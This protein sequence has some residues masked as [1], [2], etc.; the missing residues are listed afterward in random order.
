M[1]KEG[2]LFFPSHNIIFIKVLLDYI[3]ILIKVLS[4]YIFI[5]LLSEW[6]ENSIC[7]LLPLFS[8]ALRAY[9]MFG[10]RSVIR[11][12]VENVWL[13]RRKI[14]FFSQNYSV[15]PRNLPYPPF[16][17]SCYSARSW[18]WDFICC[19]WGNR[20][21]IC[22]NRIS[23]C[24]NRISI[25]GNRISFCANRIKRCGNNVK[26]YKINVKL[27]RRNVMFFWR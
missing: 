15:I 16:N 22:D 13:W 24:D 27:W 9:K 26:R 14:G 19:F 12:R 11:H 4:N 18:F 2:A 20:S 6:H 10:Q 21:S 1:P 5:N 7:K 17:I 3:F 8:R 23:I 25:C